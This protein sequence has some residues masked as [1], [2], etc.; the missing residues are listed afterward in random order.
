MKYGSEVPVGDGPCTDC[1]Q[2]NPFIWW[3]DN[4][5]WNA[6]CRTPE[7]GP[8]PTLCPTCFVK[9]L[10]TQG[11]RPESIRLIPEYP[12]VKERPAFCHINGPVPL[13]S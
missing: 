4:V 6:V 5:V 13:I 12:A 2:V 1:G 3:T 8:E 10:H 11:F 7:S 9:R